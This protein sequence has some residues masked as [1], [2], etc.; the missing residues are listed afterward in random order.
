MPLG[1]YKAFKR[2]K[3]ANTTILYTHNIQIY[4]AVFAFTSLIISVLVPPLWGL[5]M[6]LSKLSFLEWFAFIS[7]G[8]TVL[9]FIGMGLYTLANLLRLMFHSIFGEVVE[10]S[11]LSENH[12]AATT[13]L[14]GKSDSK[15]YTKAIK[16]LMGNNE[17]LIAENKK[18]MSEYLAFV[19]IEDKQGAIK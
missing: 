15:E 5:T 1:R 18:L 2:R 6:I 19:A 12:L 9:F 10:M 16:I 11:N 8:I 17:K 13:P 3:E 7:G 14:K 4:L